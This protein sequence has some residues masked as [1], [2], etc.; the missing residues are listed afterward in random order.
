[1]FEETLLRQIEIKSLGVLGL[2]TAYDWESVE[3]DLKKI[4]VTIDAKNLTV[5]SL[6]GRVPCLSG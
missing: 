2:L 5:E 4:L 6:E 1:V 3:A